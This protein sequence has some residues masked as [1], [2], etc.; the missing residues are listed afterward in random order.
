MVGCGAGLD[1]EVDGKFQNQMIGEHYRLVVSV[2]RLSWC[3]SQ[4]R[5]TAG[6]C[7]QVR[8]RTMDRRI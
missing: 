1:E 4:C 3:R 7:P 6:E 5:S 8:K 2:F